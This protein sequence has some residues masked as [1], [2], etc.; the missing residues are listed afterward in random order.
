MYKMNFQP[1]SRKYLNETIEFSR[2][3]LGPLSLQEQNAIN[4]FIYTNIN[5]GNWPYINRFYCGSIYHKINALRSFS[6][7]VNSALIGSSIH[8]ILNLRAVGFDESNGDLNINFVPPENYLTLRTYNNAGITTTVCV[9]NPLINQT[10][11]NSSIEIL[12]LDLI[13]TEQT[14]YL[15]GIGQSNGAQIFVKSPDLIA[16][17]YYSFPLNGVKVIS[18]SSSTAGDG[19]IKE[20]QV[21]INEIPGNNDLSRFSQMAVIGLT[22]SKIY[23]KDVLIINASVPSTRMAAGAATGQGWNLADSGN[24][25]LKATQFYIEAINKYPTKN[26]K[27]IIF[28]THGESDALV[29]NYAN[30]WYNNKIA[31]YEYI[32][33]I[34]QSETGEKNCKIVIS[35]LRTDYNGDI[36]LIEII[37]A[38]NVLLATNL[39]N[40]V[41]FDTSPYP[42]ESP[43]VHYLPMSAINM[44]IEKAIYI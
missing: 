10:L 31:E 14:N 18:A 21:G 32:R 38:A 9:C 36:N 27:T 43:F 40:V 13:K 39:D 19:I 16:N 23:K 28:D 15:L 34:V 22:A 30:L 17:P 25:T 6:N 26:P 44:G 1:N 11:L 33:D 24:L 7:P 29:L 5:N 35:Q 2:R 12:L 4:K 20:Y 37:R 8:T 41:L 42:L 3:C